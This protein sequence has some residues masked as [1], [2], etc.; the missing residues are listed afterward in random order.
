LIYLFV[1]CLLISIYFFIRFFK[2]QTRKKS[3]VLFS[4]FFLIIGLLFLGIQVFPNHQ[5]SKVT[6]KNA[7][8]NSS[9]ASVELTKQAYVQ[10]LNSLG[11]INLLK[12]IPNYGIDLHGVSSKKSDDIKSVTEIN[13]T[14][15]LKYKAALGHV[16]DL[17]TPE[18]FAQF[19]SSLQDILGEFAGC[20]EEMDK[21]LSDPNEETHLSKAIALYRLSSESALKLTKLSPFSELK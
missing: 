20:M 15:L 4:I 10:Q 2:D 21:H 1:I 6:N 3:L 9:A 19:H 16:L 13:Q 7:E 18:D 12:V 8:N 11:I 17:K 14:Y 5:N